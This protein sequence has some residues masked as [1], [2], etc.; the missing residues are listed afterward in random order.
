MD[1]QLLDALAEILADALLADLEQEM[2]QEQVVSVATA[3]SPRGIGSENT[4]SLVAAR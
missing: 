2:E 1:A 3:E 4:T